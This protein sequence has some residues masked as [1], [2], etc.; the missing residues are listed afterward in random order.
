MLLTNVHLQN[1][2]VGLIVDGLIQTTAVN[3]MVNQNVTGGA[4]I[5]KTLSFKWCGGLVQGGS[6]TSPMAYGVK[7]ASSGGISSFNMTGVYFEVNAAEAMILA[8]VDG[9]EI[10]LIGIEDCRF[11]HSDCTTEPRTFLDFNTVVGLVN[12][13]VKVRRVAG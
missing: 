13:G 4:L 11:T 3:L 12:G 6:V 2:D 5:K 9:K 10:G 7:L 8:K 1:N